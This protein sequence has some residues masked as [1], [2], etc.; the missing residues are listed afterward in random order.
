M[1]NFFFKQHSKNE[2]QLKIFFKKCHQNSFFHRGSLEISGRWK[3]TRVPPDSAM[4]QGPQDALRH[5][6]T[7]QSPISL[8]RILSSRWRHT[9]RVNFMQH[10]QGEQQWNGESLGF[11]AWRTRFPLDFSIAFPHHFL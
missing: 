6:C 1:Q 11:L 9:H 8:S 10:K 5:I 2:R 7:V 3:N 4:N